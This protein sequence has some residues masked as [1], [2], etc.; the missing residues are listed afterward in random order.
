MKL[1]I[2]EKEHIVDQYTVKGVPSSSITRMCKDLKISEKKLDKW[3]CGQTCG[4]VGGEGMI[5]P[6]DLKRFLRGLPCID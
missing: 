2:N 1:T 3:L 4:L 6:W 5:Y